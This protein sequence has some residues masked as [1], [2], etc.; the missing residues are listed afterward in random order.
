MKKQPSEWFNIWSNII[1]EKKEVSRLKL[2]EE[3]GCSIWTVKSLARDFCEF[4]AF[5]NYK[6]GKFTWWT[7]RLDSLLSTLSEKDRNE[8]K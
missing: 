6:N 4:E 7:P 3:S 8:L 1:K 5:V 2:A